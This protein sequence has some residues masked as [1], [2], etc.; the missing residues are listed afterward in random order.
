MLTA[1]QQRKLQLEKQI[2]ENFHV[3]WINLND[4]YRV[5]I[6]NHFEEANQFLHD[7]KQKNE[8]VLVHCQVGISR[9]SSIVLAYLMK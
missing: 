2:L 1:N 4:D 9:S 8:K 7:C 3:L 5:N 6:K